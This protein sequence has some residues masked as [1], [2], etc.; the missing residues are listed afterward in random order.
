[1][2]RLAII[3]AALLFIASAE[4]GNAWNSTNVSGALP[5]LRFAM[6][7]AADG[8]AV[9][10]ANFKGK[11][12][13]LYFGYTY[14]PDVCPATLLNITNMVGSLGKRADDVRVLFVT[15]DPARDSLPI[16]RK[17]THAFAPEIVGLRGTPN[18]IAA[19]AKRYRVTYSAQPAT[20]GGRYEVTHSSAVYVFD[21]EGNIRLL[22]SGLAESNANLAPEKADLQELVRSPAG[23]SWWRR[24]IS[25]L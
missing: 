6:T 9:T 21:R 12:V 18:E 14:C 20:K 24:L 16:L 5:P 10:E 17:Y 15:V 3:I 13:L 22:F 25:L 1:M 4:T 19:L 2:Q 23:E 11:I 8:K 7:E